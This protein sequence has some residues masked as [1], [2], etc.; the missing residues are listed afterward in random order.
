MHFDALLKLPLAPG[1]PAVIHVGDGFLAVFLQPVLCVD[2][3]ALF[4]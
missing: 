4:H 3:D 2:A 1:F